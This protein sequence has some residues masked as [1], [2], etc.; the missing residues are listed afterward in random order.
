[1]SCTGCSLAV[2]PDR[3]LHAR[4]WLNRSRYDDVTA[5][6]S[7][8][9]HHHV[10]IILIILGCFIDWI[11]SC[12]SRPRSSC[13]RRKLGFDLVWPGA[14]FCLNRDLPYL[15]PFGPLPSIEA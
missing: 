9:H 2:R 11:A 3:R 14:L 4:R 5:R 10:Q 6:S 15:P 8:L 13:R 7:D 12:S 1:V